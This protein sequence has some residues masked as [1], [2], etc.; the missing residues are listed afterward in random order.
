MP[1]QGFGT[2]GRKREQVDKA[3][4]SNAKKK[5]WQEEHSDEE[6]GEEKVSP[7]ELEAWK[8]KVAEEERQEQEEKE[9]RETEEKESVKRRERETRERKE[10]EAAEA[11]KAAEELRREREQHER[12]ER[13]ERERAEAEAKAARAALEPPPVQLPPPPAAVPAP[14][15]QLSGATGWA[16]P[17]VAAAPAPPVV[18]MMDAAR[19]AL[20][21]RG[22]PPISFPRNPATNAGSAA[23][24]ASSQGTGAPAAAE[25]TTTYVQIPADRVK[26]IIGVQGRNIKELKQRSG[27]TKVGVTDRSEPA[28]VELVGTAMAVS[29]CREMVLSIAR[30]D[31]SCIGN[32][33]EA[34]DIEQRLVPKLIGPKGQHIQMLKDQSGCYLSVR[35]L[36]PGQ[37]AKVYIT[38]PPDCVEKGTGL[39]LRWLDE[40]AMQAQQ[41]NQLQGMMGNHGGPGYGHDV[42]M[43]GGGQWAQGCGGGCGY[44][45]EMPGA[46]PGAMGCGQLQEA[47]RIAHHQIPP[48]WGGGN[49]WAD[50]AAQWGA[51]PAQGFAGGMVGHHSGGAAANPNAAAMPQGLQPQWGGA[52]PAPGWPGQWGSS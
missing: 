34:V 11:R 13:E 39:L 14:V 24:V 48:Q 46:M 21:S 40:V 36:G 47:P 28:T 51:D 10:R 33:T 16:P 1:P 37:P 12:E 23:A 20:W 32:C 27:V 15:P 49:Q 30:G 45:Q 42:Q 8:A 9:R 18:D 35:E 25:S 17:P 6:S 2:L 4:G 38:G 50:P 29:T 41:P 5:K 43:G 31:Q 52:A 44:G 3:P 7:E 22:A 26:D 19:A